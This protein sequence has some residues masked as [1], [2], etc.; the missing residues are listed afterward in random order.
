M[1]FL[2]LHLVPICICNVL[3][4]MDIH[5]STSIFLP[6][7]AFSKICITWKLWSCIVDWRGKKTANIWKGAFLMDRKWLDW[8]DVNLLAFNSVA[9]PSSV[10]FMLQF[11]WLSWAWRC[12]NVTMHWNPSEHRHKGQSCIFRLTWL[13]LTSL[14]EHSPHGKNEGFHLFVLLHMCIHSVKWSQMKYNVHVHVF[15]LKVSLS[16]S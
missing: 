8:N 4:Q 9:L 11:H 6:S 16:Y 10:Y 1:H 13:S 3:L 15:F 12:S 7:P 5:C 2:M 14:R